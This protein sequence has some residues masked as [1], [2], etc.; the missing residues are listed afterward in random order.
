VDGDV[1]GIPVG[2]PARAVTTHL[3]AL[4]QTQGAWWLTRSGPDGEVVLAGPI[5]SD[6][7]GL[8]FAFLDNEGNETEDATEAVSVR[9]RV[10]VDPGQGRGLE[11]SVAT[12]TLFLD[13]LGR[14]R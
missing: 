5:P 7:T 3:Y 14:N 1:T 13:L 11:G 2:A 9:L 6:G 12:D 10:I 4:G 8:T